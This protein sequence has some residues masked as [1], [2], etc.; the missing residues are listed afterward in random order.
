M[1]T[2]SESDRK[3]SHLPEVVLC[4]LLRCY[5]LDLKEGGVGAGVALCALVTNNTS[6]GVESDDKTSEHSGRQRAKRL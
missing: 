4:V 2:W 3:C 6:L 1:N 5:T